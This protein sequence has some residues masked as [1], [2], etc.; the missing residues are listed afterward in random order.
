MCLCNERH[1][2]LL[3]FIQILR[4]TDASDTINR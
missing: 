1:G 2:S 4:Q 3:Q